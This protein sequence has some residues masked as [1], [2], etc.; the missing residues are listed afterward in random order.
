MIADQPLLQQISLLYYRF[1]RN[2][3]DNQLANHVLSQLNELDYEK[4]YMDRLLKKHGI[5]QSEWEMLEDDLQQA[6]EKTRTTEEAEEL[7]ELARSKYGLIEQQVAEIDNVGYVARELHLELQHAIASI[8]FHKKIRA[9]DIVMHNFHAGIA[10]GEILG[11]ERDELW[12][13]AEFLE[14]ATPEKLGYVV[15]AD[16]LEAAVQIP[17]SVQTTTIESRM[18]SGRV[19]RFGDRRPGVRVRT[20]RRRRYR[21]RA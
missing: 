3:V 12:H 14:H 19:I 5:I 21:R 9:I 15:D 4:Y 10:P 20:H 1:T 2:E 18:P 17:V 16:P 7:M 11:L 13:L 8:G 6:I